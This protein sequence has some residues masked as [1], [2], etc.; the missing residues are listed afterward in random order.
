MSDNYYALH[1]FHLVLRLDC[2]LHR[3]RYCIVAV[4]IK[5]PGTSWL[6]EMQSDEANMSLD[7][8]AILL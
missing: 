7:L 2:L 8:I 1:F 5:E 3:Q 4:I 6:F